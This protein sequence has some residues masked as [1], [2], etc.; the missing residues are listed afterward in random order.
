MKDSVSLE[1]VPVRFSDV[2]SHRGPV[3][4]PKLA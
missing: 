3:L 2:A 1:F 4:T